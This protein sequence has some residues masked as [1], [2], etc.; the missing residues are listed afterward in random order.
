MCLQAQVYGQ[1]PLRGP[2]VGKWEPKGTAR[3]EKPKGA[4]RKIAPLKIEGISGLPTPVDAPISV[5]AL[6]GSRNLAVT[7]RQPPATSTPSRST[8]QSRFLPSTPT[9]RW[10]AAWRSPSELPRANRVAGQGSRRTLGARRSIARWSGG[11]TPPWPVL[12]LLEVANAF[13][14]RS[15]WGLRRLRRG[16]RKLP[17]AP[18]SLEPRGYL[19]AGTPRRTESARDTHAHSHP[20]VASKP[21][22]D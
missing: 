16:D 18:C 10:L 3:E 4:T 21:D 22:P 19:A 12:Y 7:S 5:M 15:S 17:A 2:E 8:P 11:R 1:T 14:A 9:G 6:H 13:L 20:S